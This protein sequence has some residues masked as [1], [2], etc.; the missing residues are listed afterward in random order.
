MRTNAAI[1]ETIE[2][3]DSTLLTSYILT[4]PALKVIERMFQG[5]VQLPKHVESTIDAMSWSQKQ[6]LNESLISHY[7]VLL[8]FKNMTTQNARMKQLM[9]IEEQCTEYLL[10][11]KNSRTLHDDKL[12]RLIELISFLP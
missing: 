7:A 2:D 3:L 1:L 5:K 9:G 12:A 4:S 10:K 11:L 6:K 8:K